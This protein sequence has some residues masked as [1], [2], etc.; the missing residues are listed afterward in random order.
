MF[1]LNTSTQHCICCSSL[2]NITHIKKK[3]DW[4]WRSKALFICRLHDHLSRKSNEIFKKPWYSFFVC[5]L[6]PYLWHMEVP[7]L[8]VI[9]E[10]HCLPTPQLQQCGIQ[11]VYN[12][13]HSSW[14]CWIPDPPSEAR[15]WTHIF[16]D[17]SQI[18]V[19]STTMGTSQPLLFLIGEIWKVARCEINMQ[20][21][22][23]MNNWKVK[24]NEVMPL[25][26]STKMWILRKKR[27][28]R[29][30]IDITR[31][32]VKTKSIVSIN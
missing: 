16:M 17:T 7:R 23:L 30:T 18:C 13:H 9:L 15:D 24:F 19:R 2:F 25:I 22:I 31:H 8:G 29:S 12:L 11:A 5:F 3:S 28:Q 1:A 26:N 6:G 20:K 4:K 10:L 32:K 14:H 21:N 27:C